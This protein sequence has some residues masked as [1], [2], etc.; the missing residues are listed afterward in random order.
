MQNQSIK[1]YTPDQAG[2]RVFFPQFCDVVTT[3]GDHL[4]EELAKSIKV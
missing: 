2:I 1:L 4:Q 3:L